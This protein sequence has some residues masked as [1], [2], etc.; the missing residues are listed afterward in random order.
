MSVG[1]SVPTRFN[2]VLRHSPAK[3]W[4]SNVWF[5]LNNGDLGAL[6]VCRANDYLSSLNDDKMIRLVYFV[7]IT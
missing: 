3:L 7:H 6:F 1:R 5:V 4:T 2:V